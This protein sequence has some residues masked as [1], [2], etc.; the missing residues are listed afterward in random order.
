MEAVVAPLAA[1]AAHL[2][3][4][5]G[6]HH[7]PAAAVDGHLARP[8]LGGDLAGLLEVAGLHIGGEPVLGVVADIDSLIDRVVAED[9]QDGPE[10][11]FFGD[12]HVIGD[13]R[14]DGG[15]HIVALVQTLRPAS[16]ADDQRR[17]LVDAGLDQLLDLVELHLGD[18]R[19]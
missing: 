14:K 18:D 5:E 1:V 4:A 3:A 8:Q 15:L 2:V 10:D 13:V 17:A 12:G 7:V 19:T 6:R 16:A 11:L 9:G